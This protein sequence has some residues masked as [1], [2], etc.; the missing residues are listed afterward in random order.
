[1]GIINVVEGSYEV[2]GIKFN[3]EC[4][5]INFQGLIVNFNINILVMCCNQDV[6]VGVLVIGNVN[7]LCVQLV[8]EFNVL[9]DEKLFWMMFGYGIDSFSIGQ[10]IVSSQVLVLVG[11]MGGKCIVKDIGLD[12]FSIGF[13]ELGLMDE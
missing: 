6:E 12:Q 11:N 9:D 2:F 8:F 5:I 7:Q 1:M 3:I 10:C 4:G 13:S